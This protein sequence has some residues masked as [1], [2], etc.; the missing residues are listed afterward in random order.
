MPKTG[1]SGQ[2]GARSRTSKK[3]PQTKKTTT[4]QRTTPKQR[5]QSSG[6]TEGNHTSA[7]TSASRVKA[8][9]R[10]LTKDDT[11]S[12][13]QAPS[14][15]DTGSTWTMP[16][17]RTL[18]KLLKKAYPEV[19]CALLHENPFQLLAATIL[20]AQCTDERVNRVT[21]RLFREYPDAAALAQAQPADVEEIIH[22]LGFF[23]AKASSLIG[24]AQGLMEQHDGEVP[25]D[26]SALCTLPGVG[27]KTANVVLGV[28]FGKPTG[29]VVDTHVKRISRLLGLAQAAQPEKIEQELMTILPREEWI[30]FSHRLI[31]HGRQVCIARRP[32]CPDCPLLS[33]CQRVGLPPL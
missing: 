12:D 23:R 31:Y 26:L 6:K 33:V 5:S 11:L 27:R 10:A 22:S 16:Q 14:L 8:K 18:L 19:S 28:W 13:A 7:K 25:E 9:S 21:P 2:Q 4:A 29:V 1:P 20:S 30:D 3:S 15:P 24:M 32:K 17:L